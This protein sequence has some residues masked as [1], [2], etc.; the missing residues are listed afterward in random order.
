MYKIDSLNELVELVENQE[1]DLSD[2]LSLAIKLEVNAQNNYE[3]LSKL[4][5]SPGLKK[6][7]TRLRDQEM[8]HEHIL[9]DI[10]AGFYPGKDPNTSIATPYEEW[11]V[12][13]TDN[14]FTLLRRAMEEEKKSEEFYKK[15]AYELR[16][17]NKKLISYLSYMEREHYETLRKELQEVES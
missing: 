5:I 15:L 3:S 16:G 9:R 7:L 11:N 14:V 8:E 4:E 1:F 12:N 10:F 17:S 6:T 13:E 2:L